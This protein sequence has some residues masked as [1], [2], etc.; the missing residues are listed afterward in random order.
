MCLDDPMLS[1]LGATAMLEPTPRANPE[2]APRHADQRC[3][4]VGVPAEDSV[5]V[6]L[7][8]QYLNGHNALH[9][10]KLGISLASC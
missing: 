9:F 5:I 3:H 7:T 10:R 8:P 1:R 6:L 4:P 2:R